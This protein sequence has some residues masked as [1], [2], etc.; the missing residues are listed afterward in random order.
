MKF[1]I[2]INDRDG[3]EKRKVTLDLQDKS[4]AEEWAQKQA[5]HWQWKNARIVVTPIAEE[6]VE[7]KSEAKK[8][9]APNQTKSTRPKKERKQ[10]DVSE[11]KPA[12]D[13]QFKKAIESAVAKTAAPVATESDKK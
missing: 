7:K 8:A 2:E 1:Q 4:I 3:D 5:A 12:T 9:D 6:A 11:A 13:S 10:K